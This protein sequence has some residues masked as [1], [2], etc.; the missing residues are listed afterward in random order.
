[1][2]IPRNARIPQR[3]DEDRVE[4]LAEALHLGGR[5]RFAGGEVVVGAVRQ[6]LDLDSRTID[7]LDDVEH[8]ER[9]VDDFGAYPISG[10][11]SQLRHGR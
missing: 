1:M 7:R 2:L 11:D 5:D 4:V 6:H 3:A 9:F 10:D 8:L